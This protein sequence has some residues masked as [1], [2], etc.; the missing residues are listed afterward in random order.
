MR[1]DINPEARSSNYIDDRMDVQ[2][3]AL[4]CNHLEEAA[5]V[6]K[7]SSDICVK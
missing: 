6:I 3:T 1:I 2:F 7:F 5:H 4:T